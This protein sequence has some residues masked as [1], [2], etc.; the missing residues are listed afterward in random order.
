MHQFPTIC[1]FEKCI[2]FV[3]TT[4]GSRLM[5]ISLVQIFQKN[6]YLVQIFAIYFISAI[7]LLKN[8]TNE[9]N[10]SKFALGKLQ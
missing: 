3:E 9:I 5:R 7:F 4:E 2:I 10:S 6:P 8:C 1:K